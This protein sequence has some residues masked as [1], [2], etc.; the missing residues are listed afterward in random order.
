MMVDTNCNSKVAQTNS[1]YAEVSKQHSQT[2]NASQ[3]KVDVANTS[4]IVK[5]I[6]QGS[7]LLHNVDVL[8]G[9]VVTKFGISS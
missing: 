2:R 8:S 4:S 7:K 1:A 6:L 5:V 9:L 3:I